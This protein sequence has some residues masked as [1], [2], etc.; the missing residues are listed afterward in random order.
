MDH[1]PTDPAAEGRLAMITRELMSQPFEEIT[2]ERV[3]ELAVAHVPGCS[4]ASIS[5]R[6]A[7]RRAETP[8]ANDALAEALDH[9]QYDSGDGP[10]LNT[11]DD[12]NVRLSDDLAAETR[13]PAWSPRAAAAGIA[14]VLSIRL[15][16]PERVLGSLNLYARKV[17]AFSDDSIDIGAAYAR[18]ASGVLFAAEQNGGLRT[19]LESRNVIG[20]AQGLLMGQYGLTRDQS[21]EVLRRL[22]QENHTKLRD[23]A[24]QIVAQNDRL[25]AGDDARTLTP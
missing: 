4:L 8:A 21:F 15:A 25:N 14:S 6:S 24:A 23:L 22:S 13:W 10:C 5:L 9:W 12:G 11:L 19:A 3:V 7:G 16:T 2:P 20:I 18:I 17:A 1:P